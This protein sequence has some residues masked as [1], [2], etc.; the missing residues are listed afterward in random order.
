MPKRNKI[1]ISP[2]LRQGI[3]AVWGQIAADASELNDLDNEGAI[4]L[5]YDA[6]RLSFFGY[7]A[8]DAAIKELFKKH[9]IDAVRKAIAKEVSL[10]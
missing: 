3:L 5:C 1:V 10:V 6:D 9:E 8:A 7:P 2:T 4:E